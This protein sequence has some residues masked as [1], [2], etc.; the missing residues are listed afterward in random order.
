MEKHL[1]NILSTFNNKI[2]YI[3]NSDKKIYFSFYNFFIN[4]YKNYNNINELLN[5]YLIYNGKENINKN[6]HLL[7]QFFN[8]NI[9]VDKVFI[10]NEIKR[11]NY[12][13][14]FKKYN[15]IVY[16]YNQSNII[17]DKFYIYSKWFNNFIILKSKYT[18][19][20]FKVYMPNEII[21]YINI[22]DML[23]LKIAK[24]NKSFWNILDI[25]D[26]YPNGLKSNEF[27]NMI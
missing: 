14:N 4:N 19:K 6:I 11:Y 21:K 7:T 8:F 22:N 1:F 24:N 20:L 3:N 18:N 15:N 27:Y 5:I 26:F 10:V 2:K 12:I 17:T 25:I 13:K 23:H 16:L 9:K